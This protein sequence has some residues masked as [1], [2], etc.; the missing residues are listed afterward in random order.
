MV[1]AA[2]V[3]VGAGA[4]PTGVRAGGATEPEPRP[5]HDLQKIPRKWQPAV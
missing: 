3:P 2:P 4:D 1:T 5:A